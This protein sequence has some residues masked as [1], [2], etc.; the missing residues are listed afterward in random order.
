MT[1][2][3][4]LRK[5]YGEELIILD[6]GYITHPE[7]DRIGNVLKKHIGKCNFQVDCDGFL[8]VDIIKKKSK[9]LQIFK[10]I[11]IGGKHMKSDYHW[12]HKDNTPYDV[13]YHPENVRK[14]GIPTR[15]ER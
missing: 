5:Q 14:Y 12:E 4:M 10:E 9:L 6:L 7:V 13:K 15:G 1:E 3:F 8:K 11:V 2:S